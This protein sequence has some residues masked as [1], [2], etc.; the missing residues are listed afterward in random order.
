MTEGT[1]EPAARQASGALV[2]LSAAY[3]LLLVAAAVASRFVDVPLL[4]KESELSLWIAGGLAGIA[5]IVLARALV[6]GRSPGD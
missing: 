2:A 5:A 3:L 1:P 4:N 6:R